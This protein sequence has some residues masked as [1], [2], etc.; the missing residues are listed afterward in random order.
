VETGGRRV[1]LGR[2]A[3]RRTGQGVRTSSC[4]C[5]YVCMYACMFEYENLKRLEDVGKREE[6]R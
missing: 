4:V 5:M 1:G 3:G 2:D 6:R